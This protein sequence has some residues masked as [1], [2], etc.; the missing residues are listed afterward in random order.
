MPLGARTAEDAP[1]DPGTAPVLVDGSAALVL[2]QEGGWT[3][4]LF[5]SRPPAEQADVTAAR[6]FRPRRG[7]RRRWS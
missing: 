7:C 2:R 6:A 1:T 4:N 3:Y 5:A